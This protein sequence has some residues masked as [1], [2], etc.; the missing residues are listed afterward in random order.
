MKKIKRHRGVTLAEI[1]IIIAVIGILASMMTLSSSESITTAKA[2]SII[3]NLLTI[4]KAALAWYADNR[5]VYKYLN[6][7]KLNIQ[8]ASAN[9]NDAL[10]IGKYLDDATRSVFITGNEKIRYKG[11]DYNEGLPQGK[12]G[13]F[14]VQWYRSTWYVGYRFKDDEEAVKKKVKA[15]SNTYGL[16]F[17]GMFPNPGLLDSSLTSDDI[18][19]KVEGDDTVWLYVLGNFRKTE[20]TWTNV[21]N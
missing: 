16:V 21:L 14:N 19:G 5:E 10:G 12:Y 6:E 15:R 18:D 17:S 7:N 9:L 1:L 2:T 20:K 13:I 4:R 8:G 11:K 3:N